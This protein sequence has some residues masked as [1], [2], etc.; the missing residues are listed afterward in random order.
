MHEVL[1]AYGSYRGERKKSPRKSRAEKK[2]SMT[3]ALKKKRR[4]VDE[5][6]KELLDTVKAMNLGRYRMR[7]FVG[8][9][10]IVNA[11]TKPT[12]R[13]GKKKR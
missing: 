8:G 5:V 13:L 10:V 1:Y 6:A 11:D 7:F 3:A 4:D 2:A 12:K 9:T